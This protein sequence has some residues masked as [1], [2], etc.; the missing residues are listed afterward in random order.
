LAEFVGH[1]YIV[2]DGENRHDPSYVLRIG[3][4]QK[5]MKSYLLGMTQ[6]IEI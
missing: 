5:V 2:E 3:S 4:A 6:R 1:T